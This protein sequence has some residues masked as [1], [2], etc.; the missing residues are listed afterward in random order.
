MRL[1][2]LLIPKATEA[3]NIV[4]QMQS[5]ATGICELRPFVVTF[6]FATPETEHIEKGG[7]VAAHQGQSTKNAKWSGAAQFNGS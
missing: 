7:S 3:G 4:P 6:V 1:W 5:V 2:C